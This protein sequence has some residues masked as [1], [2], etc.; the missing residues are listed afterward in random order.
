[1]R[2]KEKTPFPIA[3]SLQ[4]DNNVQPSFYLNEFLTNP[5]RSACLKKWITT[6]NTSQELYIRK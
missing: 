6:S 3:P 4:T 1:M 2:R 5:L